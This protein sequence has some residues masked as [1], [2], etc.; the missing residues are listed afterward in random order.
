MDTVCVPPNLYIVPVYT[1]Y[2]KG[3]INTPVLYIV[4]V[5]IQFQV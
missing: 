2:P 5:N 1:Q 4:P 3:L